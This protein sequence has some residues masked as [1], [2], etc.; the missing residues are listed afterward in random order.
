M[1]Q[2]GYQIIDLNIYIPAE[3]TIVQYEHIRIDPLKPIMMRI[4]AYDVE[5]NRWGKII[6][7]WFWF[8]GNYISESEYLLFSKIL[9]Y[10]ITIDYKNNVIK[11]TG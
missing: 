2:G 5:N 9:G 8:I 11:I 4:S 10:N 7:P 6:S 3:S 1:I